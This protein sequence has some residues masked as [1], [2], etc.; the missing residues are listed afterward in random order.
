MTPS[1]CFVSH[2]VNTACDSDDH[3]FHIKMLFYSDQQC[4]YV[5]THIVFRIQEHCERCNQRARFPSFPTT[6]NIVKEKVIFYKYIINIKNIAEGY[7]SC[8]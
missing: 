5:M 3:Y 6:V 4:V 7:F 2:S 8:M 1:Y